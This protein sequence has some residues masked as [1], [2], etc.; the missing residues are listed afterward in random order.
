MSILSSNGFPNKSS[1]SVLS[2]ICASW[3]SLSGPFHGISRETLLRL[4]LLLVRWS[5]YLFR[6]AQLKENLS[7]TWS[8]NKICS[9]GFLWYLLSVS[10]GCW[11]LNPWS[12][13]AECLLN[14]NSQLMSVTLHP[15]L[16]KIPL[17][18]SLKPL[19]ICMM[20]L[21]S[22]KNITQLQEVMRST[23]SV[24]LQSIRS[25]KLLSSC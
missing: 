6:L 5:H 20:S 14:T 13:G 21:K 17:S 2:D 10:L 3:L 12:Y 4:L 19:L 11:S 22:S 15:T 16:M 25:L 1:S 7:G 8:S 23:I 24:K 18:V 9:F